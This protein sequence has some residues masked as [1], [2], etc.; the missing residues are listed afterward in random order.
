M[1]STALQLFLFTTDKDIILSAGDAGISGFIIDWENKG[2]Y[3]RQ[4]E[5]D[6]QINYDS[7]ETLQYVRSLTVTH[8]ICRINRNGCL[9]E[10]K[11]EI[12]LALDGGAN[13]ILL[14][15]VRTVKE[16][17]SVLNF[18]QGRCAVGI[19]IET[20]AAVDL[21][22]ELGALPLSRVY[23]GLNDLAID[24]NKRNIFSA[25]KDGTV[26]HVRQYINVPFGFAGLTLPGCGYPVPAK[27]LYSEMARLQC[28]FTFLR[29]SFLRDIQGK[30]MANKI[31][32]M[33]QAMKNA[34]LSPLLTKE[35][36]RKEME[37]F[38][39][40]MGTGKNILHNHKSGKSIP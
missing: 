27:F 35:K 16:V 3:E 8:I 31:G 5:A 6:T 2:K 23:V 4:K 24:R 17:E 34:F 15:M 7:L 1:I 10:C 13:E 40:K 22:A 18:V 33:R 14:P 29:R 36:N 25:V 21:A 30:D 39:E 37:T 11:E 12:S 38:I 20:Q 19:L 26:D 32:E 28:S 9:H